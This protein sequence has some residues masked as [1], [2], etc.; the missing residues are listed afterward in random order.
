MDW[1]TVDGIA[2]I[3]A[4]LEGKIEGYAPPAAFAIGIT[5]ASSSAEIE[6][7]HIAAGNGGLAA[8]ILATVLHHSS[9]T[10]TYD[11]SASQLEAAITALEPAEACTQMPHPNIAA[12]RELRDELASNPARSLV[13]V[14]VADMADPVD[15]DAD[16]T[17]RA[18]LNGHEPVI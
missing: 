16:S 6:F 4:H 5:P 13:A 8:V 17:L 1:S 7:P 10:R 12:W 18:A 2:A 11:V 14:F 9:G 15:S 3:R